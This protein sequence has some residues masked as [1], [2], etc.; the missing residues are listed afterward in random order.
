MSGLYK[1]YKGITRIHLNRIVEPSLQ[2]QILCPYIEK[3]WSEDFGHSHVPFQ[4]F[5][6]KGRR[7]HNSGTFIKNQS[8]QLIEFQFQKD[9]LDKELSN[10][11]GEESDNKLNATGTPA[12]RLEEKMKLNTMTRRNHV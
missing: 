1:L 6:V 7:Y 12:L 3:H 11:A 5:D 10:N 8:Y 9:E 4:S 2:P